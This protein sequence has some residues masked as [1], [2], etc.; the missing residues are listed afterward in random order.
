MTHF[1]D[2]RVRPVRAKYSEHQSVVVS[3]RLEYAF[4]WK[5]HFGVP[6]IRRISIRGDGYEVG[7]GYTPNVT[8]RDPSSGK[9]MVAVTL[10][11]LPPGVEEGIYLLRA[12]HEGCGWFLHAWW[13]MHVDERL[14]DPIELVVS[15]G[16]PPAPPS[17]IPWTGITPRQTYHNYILD[18]GGEYFLGCF[19]GELKEDKFHVIGLEHE[20]VWYYYGSLARFR[21]CAKEGE[22]TVDVPTY[23]VD[24]PGSWDAFTWV[25]T[26]RET[27]RTLEADGRVVGIHEDD[28]PRLV[29]YDVGAFKEVIGIVAE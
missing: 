24:I 2:F 19:F 4:L 17:V 5:H 1:S 29:F 14:S 28:I 16:A 6:D 15:R 12:Y 26:F 3:G 10:P 25:G 7:V 20:G 11:G 22:A 27:V 21:A 23:A 8:Q 18:P 9:F 13:P